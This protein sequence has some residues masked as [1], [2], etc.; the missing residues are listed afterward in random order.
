MTLHNK[1]IFYDEKL[2]TPR[3]TPKLK[4]HP[5]SAVHDYLFNIFTPTL[6]TWRVSPSS[7]TWGRAMSWWQGIHLTW[8]TVHLIAYNQKISH[9]AVF[10]FSKHVNMMCCSFHQ[11]TSPPL[12]INSYRVHF[13]VAQH[14]QTVTSGFIPSICSQLRANQELFPS[15]WSKIYHFLHARWEV[16]TCMSVH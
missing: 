1:L 3:P 4:Y 10:I 8:S 15:S 7:V 9:I 14:R 13:S 2:L 5:L 12:P 11:L 6:H 16:F